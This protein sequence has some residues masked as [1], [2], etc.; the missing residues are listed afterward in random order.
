[1]HDARGH[2]HGD[3]GRV[4]FVMFRASPRPLEPRS[5]RLAPLR[6]ESALARSRERVQSAVQCDSVL[7]PVAAVNVQHGDVVL[8]LG[9]PLGLVR[10]GAKMV[11]RARLGVRVGVME[12]ARCR[13]RAMGCGERQPH[14]V[15][16]SDVDSL[17][18]VRLLRT[19]AGEHALGHV[20]QGA[21]GLG[22]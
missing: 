7:R 8:V 12:R 13:A 16:V 6:L 2:D 17:K 15:L 10:V 4:R 18:R 19:G 5:V 3:H 14:L 1:M 9:P 22:E 21:A 20:A 11:E